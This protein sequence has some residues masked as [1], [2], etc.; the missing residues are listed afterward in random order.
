MIS[1][2][3]A[4]ELLGGLLVGLSLEGERVGRGDALGRSDGLDVT[5]GVS[6]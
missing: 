2:K 6:A 3:K 1:P 5:W 4:T